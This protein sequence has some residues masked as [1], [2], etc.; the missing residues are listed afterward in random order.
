MHA[1]LAEWERN[2]S[3]GARL[4]RRSF[5]VDERTLRKAR[6]ILGTASDSE[7]IRLSV[8][9]IAEMEEFWRF[10]SKSRSRLKPGSLEIP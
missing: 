8:E 3:K 9:R 5:F 6:R 10:M 2:M 4:K 7:A 1:L